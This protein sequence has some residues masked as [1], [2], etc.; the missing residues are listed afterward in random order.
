[1]NGSCKTVDMVFVS[2]LST[3]Q[4]KKC[5]SHKKRLR[6]KGWKE[7]ENSQIW[8][9]LYNPL[10][11]TRPI[12]GLFLE[13]GNVSS[14]RTL[15]TLFD[16]FPSPCSQLTPVDVVAEFR[17]EYSWDLCLQRLPTQ[18]LADGGLIT[19]VQLLHNFLAAT[20]PGAELGK[21]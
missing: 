18:H 1:M 20:D 14:T 19:A 12:L 3:Q 17:K 9:L 4:N 13:A 6:L 5:L 2:G 15:Y 11:A 21:K 16:K 7:E 10:K 8:Q